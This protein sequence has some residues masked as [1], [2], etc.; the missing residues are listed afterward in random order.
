MKDPGHLAIDLDDQFVGKLEVAQLNTTV[1]PEHFIMIA[2]NID[3]PGT[4]TQQVENFLYDLQ[5]GA[6][7]IPFGKLPSINDIPVQDQQAGGYTPEIV[8]YFTGMASVSA[9]M[10][11]G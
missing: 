6:G 3:H 9:E 2:G 1:S 10:E 8:D 4:F 5:V 7:E 11:I